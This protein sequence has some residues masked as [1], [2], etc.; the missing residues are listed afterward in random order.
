MT[1]QEKRELIEGYECALLSA[2]DDETADLYDRL[3]VK[4]QLE[5]LGCEVV[6]IVREEEEQVG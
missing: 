4:F 1:I 2:E 5:L 3:A 6:E